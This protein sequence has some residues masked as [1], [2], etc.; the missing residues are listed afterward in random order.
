MFMASCG[1]PKQSGLSTPMR[2][3]DMTALTD[4]YHNITDSTPRATR[5]AKP[6]G[7]TQQ[8]LLRQCII[9]HPDS[10]SEATVHSNSRSASDQSAFCACLCTLR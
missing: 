7:F 2:S 8:K 10:F 5:W 6:L 4:M 3:V 9:G 1:C